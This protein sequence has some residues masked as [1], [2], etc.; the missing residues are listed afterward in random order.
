MPFLYLM[1]NRKCHPCLQ[2]RTPPRPPG[3]ISA[4]LPSPPNGVLERC[5]SPADSPTALGRSPYRRCRG[6]AAHSATGPATHGACG[7]P[8]Q[9]NP[10][11]VFMHRTSL[12]D[13]GCSPRLRLSTRHTIRRSRNWL[14]RPSSGGADG[15]KVGIWPG[16]DAAQSQASSSSK[17]LHTVPGVNYVGGRF[18]PVISSRPCRGAHEPAAGTRGLGALGG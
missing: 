13:T 16:S 2:I 7:G 12:G 10:W 6:I 8:A 9:D 5:S 11:A 18:C 1:P 17:Q 14:C 15:H 4:Q 3:W